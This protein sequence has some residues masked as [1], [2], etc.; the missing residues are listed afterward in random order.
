MPKIIQKITEES[1]SFYRAIALA[2]AR[3]E[4]EDAC[5]NIKDKVVQFLNGLK[6]VQNPAENYW[7]KNMIKDLQESLQ[8][9]INSC[10]DE[11]QKAR[12]KIQLFSITMLVN[13]NN[14]KKLIEKYVEHLQTD[15]DTVSDFEAELVSEALGI[16]IGMVK[17]VDAD[18]YDSDDDSVDSND[19]PAVTPYIFACS[20][21]PTQVICLERNASGHCDLRLDNFLPAINLDTDDSDIAEALTQVARRE[22]SANNYECVKTLQSLASRLPGF[23]ITA[24][25][26][27]CR[28]P[29][30]IGTNGLE[31][32]NFNMIPLV[33]QARAEILARQFDVNWLLTINATNI[34]NM[35]NGEQDIPDWLTN[36][37]E[38]NDNNDGDG[39][40]NRTQEEQLKDLATYLHIAASRKYL[41]DVDA[42]MAEIKNALINANYLFIND[43]V[44]VLK[45]INE[46]LLNSEW[47]KG[48]DAAQ[49]QYFMNSYQ[50]RI[51]HEINTLENDLLAEVRANVFLD[52]LFSEEDGADD[53]LDEAIRKALRSV[54]NSE[55]EEEDSE[56]EDNVIAD[57]TISEDTRFELRRRYIEQNVDKVVAY[58]LNNLDFEEFLAFLSDDTGEAHSK[59][60][61]WFD[62]RGCVDD[63]NGWRVDTDSNDSWSN[64]FYLC[65][66][67]VLEGHIQKEYG[68]L[69]FSNK[70]ADDAGRYSAIFD[71]L[72]RLGVPR[73][74]LN[75]MYPDGTTQE[76]LIQR[77]RQQVQKKFF[78]NNNVLI[79][80]L[81]KHL[82]ISELD[83]LSHLSRDFV[84]QVTQAMYDALNTKVPNSLPDP[85][86]F[87]FFEKNIVDCAMQAVKENEGQADTIAAAKAAIEKL[88]PVGIALEVK[89]R[90]LGLTEMAV[91]AAIAAKN[92]T[93]GKT[94][95]VI[96]ADDIKAAIISMRSATGGN[97]NLTPEETAIQDAMIAAIP[98]IQPAIET[99]VNALIVKATGWEGFSDGAKY[100]GT[101]EACAGDAKV[102]HVKRIASLFRDAKNVM[103]IQK[104]YFFADTNTNPFVEGIVTRI[105]LWPGN[106]E[107]KKGIA[108]AFRAAY[109]DQNAQKALLHHL[110]AK[111]VDE[112]LEDDALPDTLDN[113][114]LDQLDALVDVSKA[115]IYE[116]TLKMVQGLEAIE[117][118]KKRT[119]WEIHQ[120]T[121]VLLTETGNS[122]EAIVKAIVDEAAKLDFNTKINAELVAALQPIIDSL[123]TA[124]GGAAKTR[125][126]KRLK[127]IAEMAVIAARAAHNKTY[128]IVQ[129]DIEAAYRSTRSTPDKNISDNGTAL[130]NNVAARVKEVVPRVL[131]DRFI[132]EAVGIRNL[133]KDTYVAALTNIQAAALQVQQKREQAILNGVFSRLP[134]ELQLQI[135]AIVNDTKKTSDLKQTE[136]ITLLK[137][138]DRRVN[139]KGH[140]AKTEE[141]GYKLLDIYHRTNADGFVHRIGEAVGTNLTKRDQHFNTAIETF[142][143]RSIYEQSGTLAQA[144][145]NVC[146]R[147]AKGRADMP[148]L[149]SSFWLGLQQA[150][151]KAE[152]QTLLQSAGI[153]D[154]DVPTWVAKTTDY[155]EKHDLMATFSENSRLYDLATVIFAQK[156]ALAV[157]DRIHN[158]ALANVLKA[159]YPKVTLDY[160][161]VDKINKF[162]KEQKNFDLADENTRTAFLELFKDK[163]S[164]LQA[165]Q[166]KALH[167]HLKAKANAKV[168]STNHA[169]YQGL[170]TQLKVIQKAIVDSTNRA[171]QKKADI[172][173]AK[174]RLAWLKEQQQNTE[175]EMR[176]SDL[177]AE[178]QRELS[179]KANQF[180]ESIQRE[181]AVIVDS[182]CNQGLLVSTLQQAYIQERL[183]RFLLTKR[184]L[185]NNG[186]T[187][188]EKMAAEIA[189]KCTE[190][191][192]D[193][194]RGV[195]RNVEDLNCFMQ[196]NYGQPKGIPFMT[197]DD[198]RN[199]MEEQDLS[200]E[201]H[202]G[203]KGVL[204]Q[205]TQDLTRKLGSEDA[206][207]KTVAHLRDA[208]IPAGVLES[209]RTGVINDP[210]FNNR[211]WTGLGATVGAGVG[212]EVGLA[213]T[214]GIGWGGAAA[215]AGLVGVSI[216]SGGTLTLPYIGAWWLMASGGLAGGVAGTALAKRYHNEKLTSDSFATT[217]EHIHTALDRG[218]GPISYNLANDMKGQVA[219]LRQYMANI[220][221]Y[222]DDAEEAIE[223]L[224]EEVENLETHHPDDKEAIVEYRQKLLDLETEIKTL[225]GDN[226]YQYEVRLCG[227]R[228]AQSD[229]KDNRVYIYKNEEDQ[230]V[231]CV[232][233]R[234]EIPL[235]VGSATE[236][237]IFAKLPK[238]G[239]KPA[240]FTEQACVDTVLEL[241]GKAGFTPKSTY[242][243][244]KGWQQQLEHIEERI[245]DVL[246]LRNDN[247][248]V[249]EERPVEK[250]SR[251]ERGRCVDMTKEDWQSAK[252]L[253]V[254]TSKEIGKKPDFVVMRAESDTEHF[255][256]EI[257]QADVRVKAIS[258]EG[259]PSV[260]FATVSELSAGNF[261]KITGECVSHTIATYEAFNYKF[262]DANGL[263][264]IV[265]VPAGIARNDEGA[266]IRES[267]GVK[268]CK[269]EYQGLLFDNRP[270][271]YKDANAVF[272]TD[273][274]NKASF[275]AESE[276]V[277]AQRAFSAISD[278]I[279]EFLLK[280]KEFPN[281]NC[282][283]VIQ[284]NN[285]T[286]AKYLAAACAFYEGVFPGK[287]TRS[288]YYA[289][290]DAKQAFSVGTVDYSNYVSEKGIFS[291]S[292]VK[293]EKTGQPPY[294]NYHESGKT[295]Q[296]FMKHLGCMEPAK[297]DNEP[298]PKGLSPTILNAI[299]DCKNACEGVDSATRLADRDTQTMFGKRAKVAASRNELIP[300]DVSEMGATDTDRIASITTGLGNGG[301]A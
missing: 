38:D 277:K 104:L 155:G 232:K 95:N 214:S 141:V 111:A 75:R 40:L 39:V 91:L 254:L 158:A 147:Q 100:L 94:G 48:L 276:A 279:V 269:V 196:D 29:T 250:A 266:I 63:L 122:I 60:G 216:G 204:V 291:T 191:Y 30:Y 188:Y 76:N 190:L 78:N 113:L 126:D 299:Q 53:N 226:K 10:K 256:P 171:K 73:T 55:E 286:D 208:L 231:C 82:N 183:A 274:K 230:L 110:Q 247:T 187:D 202:A 220:V 156:Q 143:P 4:N 240:K 108:A 251:I 281:S 46:F 136:I 151:T 227:K 71:D 212:A 97:V 105:M 293:K 33:Y 287:F 24:A 234:K 154:A 255:K 197:E 114:R 3:Y 131:L 118:G 174:R 115:F 160:K 101:L 199:V 20:Q 62:E 149:S 51:L 119:R 211:V 246:Y 170:M 219:N 99:R 289:T 13:A 295:M 96:P 184:V 297:K 109:N 135:Q 201:L 64:N 140:S 283:M 200:R 68:H 236:N 296:D 153:T 103:D 270:V 185:L 166:S 217:L 167:D 34:Q 144:F 162:L 223:R 248:G 228:P 189:Q 275:I 193:K 127:G 203:N 133:K 88:F 265:Q 25:L 47:G 148:A 249:L 52:D 159:L 290:G 282:P 70:Y 206:S 259:F 66:Q 137:N 173:E 112:L 284:V 176:R 134:R 124:L 242:D 145:D 72:V 77:L 218:L 179:Q 22:Y 198:F 261:R 93:Y 59:L 69:L 252:R 43:P 221:G 300:D 222:F 44:S 139:D 50:L 36:I 23:Y 8:K 150:K 138:S 225:R 129:A 2:Y 182:E 164:Q 186:S 12:L 157:Y 31:I 90:V 152:V 21:N 241:T 26:K 1:N 161:D 245:E 27:E 253:T 84:Y 272:Q 264:K 233:G 15:R 168:I 195:I 175:D 79:D 292:Y 213:M 267:D 285:A 9:Q 205:R 102:D 80:E 146:V 169:Y 215:L 128:T 229:M 244:Y 28:K 268:I 57:Y 5:G 89:A 45:Y 123:T 172:S 125:I 192:E 258:V 37:L 65:L 107:V 83:E 17:G 81:S 294:I 19:G 209:M 42:V 56:E 86:N 224:K 130:I 106:N 6:N 243:V 32:K 87:A 178:Q 239:D 92:R 238:E 165:P 271:V 120:H 18:S 181:E 260:G 14:F 210:T 301:G 74:E 273:T 54:K 11:T 116:S 35:F 117:S 177:T 98:K 207:K 142:L 85:H 257:A 61:A 180:Q 235:N 16:T 41:E 280:K 194:N 262:K 288:S 298:L 67:T 132:G 163:M 49:V 278:M 237:V 121:P 58:Y 263:D 7:V